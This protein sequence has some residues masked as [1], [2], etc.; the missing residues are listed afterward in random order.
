MI[1][2]YIERSRFENYKAI[3]LDLLQIHCKKKFQTNLV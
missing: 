2:M 3:N 1:Y